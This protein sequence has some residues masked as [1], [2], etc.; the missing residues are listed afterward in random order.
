M[1]EVYVAERLRKGFGPLRV[2]Q[3]LR[4]RGLADA[5]IEPHLDRP[6][7][8]WLELMAAVQEKKFGSQRAADRKE[9]ARRARFLEHRGFP[10]EL[11]VRLLHGDDFD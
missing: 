1:A 3:E 4:R 6:P 9:L 11:I 8:Q 2:R 5:L 10:A 7:Q